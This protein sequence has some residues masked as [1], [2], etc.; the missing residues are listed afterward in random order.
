MR[1]ILPT[2][3][4]KR[5]LLLYYDLGNKKETGFTFKDAE[6]ILSKRL[7]DDSRIV[8]LFLS[9]LRRAEWLEAVSDKDD[10]RRKIY[11]LR[12]YTTIYNN[13]VEGMPKI[14]R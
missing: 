4:M 13:F 3:V 6:L 2:W 14:K 9:S 11:K 1:V 10:A 7:K 5:Y 8:A 12:D